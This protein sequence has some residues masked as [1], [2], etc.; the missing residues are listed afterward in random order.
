MSNPQQSELKTAH[1]ATVA[2][3]TEVTHDP[4]DAMR[5]AADLFA[6]SAYRA[7]RAV[8]LETGL[9]S[10]TPPKPLSKYLRIFTTSI[11]ARL[12]E[13]AGLLGTDELDRLKKLGPALARRM[14][15]NDPDL[16]EG[17]YELVCMEPQD[18][19]VWIHEHLDHIEARFAS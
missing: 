12:M 18:A 7:E 11:K 13:T 3:L 8:A 9:S 16:A 6:M 14:E 4:I 19:A 5:L 2:T 15:R 10:P 1:S 17:I